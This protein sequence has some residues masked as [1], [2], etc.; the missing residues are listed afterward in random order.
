MIACTQDP[1]IFDELLRFR[2]DRV[3]LT[4]DAEKAFLMVGMAEEDSCYFEGVPERVVRCSLLGFGDASSKTFTAV[5][6]LHVTRRL[7]VKFVASK[8]R[9]APA[10]QFSIPRL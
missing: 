9:V 8:S 2:A 6:Y 10:K 7:Y 4:G 5:I 3:D 1:S